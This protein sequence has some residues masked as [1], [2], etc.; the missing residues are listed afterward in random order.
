M[1]LGTYSLRR[2]S[3]LY[4]DL[5]SLVLSET[6]LQRMCVKQYIISLLKTLDSHLDSNHMW[7]IERH[8]SGIYEF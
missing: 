5:V 6:L 1:G 4:S 7:C 3:L 2:G 8:W